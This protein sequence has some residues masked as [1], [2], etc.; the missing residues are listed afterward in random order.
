MK[1][2][3]TDSFQE[4]WATITR[5]KFRSIATGFG[6]FW[7]LFMLIVL[8]S[9]GNKLTISIRSMFG[10]IAM[11]SVFM[12]P[13]RTTEPYMGYRKGRYWEFNNRD[14]ELIRQRAN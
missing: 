2:F 10:D 12:Q 7:G 11:N 14:L 13:N 5:N 1:F 3:D 9:I 8:L 4:I 6:V